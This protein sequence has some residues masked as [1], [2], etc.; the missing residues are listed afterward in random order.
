MKLATKSKDIRKEN[1]TKILIKIRKF[2]KSLFN[3]KI[4]RF[5][6]KFFSKCPEIGKN[7]INYNPKIFFLFREKFL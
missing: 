5:K 7:T 2:K 3:A 4:F 1:R 6:L